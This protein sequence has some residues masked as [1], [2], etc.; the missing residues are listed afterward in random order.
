MTHHVAVALI[1]LAALSA[2]CLHAGDVKAVKPPNI[3]M[4]DYKTFSW[5]PIRLATST[6]E[7]ENDEVFAPAIKTAVTAELTKR[8]LSEV[9]EGAD[10]KV[11]VTAVQTGMYQVEGWLVTFGFD[12]YWG[13]GYGMV[14]E[15]NRYNKEGTLVIVLAESKTKKGVW[16]GM[17]T[18][19]AG[20]RG[21]PA[22]K[23]NKATRDIFKKFPK[24]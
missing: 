1:A 8:G 12:A 9:T 2:D 11:Y 17:A 6:G 22:D 7:T 23:V 13:V 18:E 14:R 19:P 10:L 15:V 16:A 3:K 21:T 5:T 20:G 4:S 24:K